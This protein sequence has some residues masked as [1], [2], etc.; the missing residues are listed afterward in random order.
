MTAAALKAFTDDGLF[1]GQTN[2]Q[3]VDVLN[4][5][6]DDAGAERRWETAARRLK[7]ENA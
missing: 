7:H 4:D 5:L 3:F 6:A 1:N 2:Q